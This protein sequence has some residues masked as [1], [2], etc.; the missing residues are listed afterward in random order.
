MSFR[1]VFWPSQERTLAS[2]EIELLALYATML[3]TKRAEVSGALARLESGVMKLREANASVAGMKVEL[4]ELQ[5]VLDHPALGAEV[6]VGERLFFHSP[7]RA[8]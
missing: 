3:H 8:S 6:R 5:P 4:S 7:R 2:K 1:L